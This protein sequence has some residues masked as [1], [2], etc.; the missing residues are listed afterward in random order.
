[1]T[2]EIGSSRRATRTANPLS[3]GDLLGDELLVEGLIR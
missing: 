3:D 2:L 1:M